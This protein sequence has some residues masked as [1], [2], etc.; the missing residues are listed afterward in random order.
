[1]FGGP[2]FSL[3]LLT[4]FARQKRSVRHGRLSLSLFSLDLSCNRIGD[5]GLAA[6]VSGIRATAANSS[7]ETLQLS[8]NR[9][10]MAGLRSMSTLISLDSLNLKS[11]QH[12]ELKGIDIGDDEAKVL[13]DALVH[14]KS[15]VRLS[16]DIL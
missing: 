7:L 12:L 13:A 2:F 10:S 14:N 4:V 9:F 11:F 1:L 3:S 15:L 5:K 16:L 6:F 8:H